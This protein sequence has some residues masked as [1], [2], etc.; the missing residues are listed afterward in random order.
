[1]SL[2]GENS[3]ASKPR[4]LKYYE[5]F[6]KY[7]IHNKIED[8]VEKAYCLLCD[9]TFK[10]GSLKQ[11]NLRRHQVSGFLNICDGQPTKHLDIQKEAKHPESL[12]KGQEFFQQFVPIS[13]RDENLNKVDPLSQKL[14]KVSYDISFLIAKNGKNHTIGE[15]LLKP[16]IMN[17]VE[18]ILGVE[19]AANF[20]A[21][22]VSAGTVK[23]RIVNISSYIELETVRKL[24]E[25]PHF[26]MQLDESTDIVDLAELLVYVRYMV[27][28][29]IEESML[30]VKP[31]PTTTTGAD[32]FNL[33]DSYFQAQ[34]IDWKKCSSIATDGA[35]ALT[36]RH[37]GFIAL[38]KKVCF[39]CNYFFKTNLSSKFSIGEPKCQI[40]TLCSTSRSIGCQSDGS[41]FEKNTGY[42]CT[43]D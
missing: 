17:S 20:Q 21:I 16:V 42:S 35:P 1:M 29:S 19:A 38:V 10:Q 33:V 36:G 13:D 23:R 18:T 31:L 2:S 7:G 43:N 28:D 14:L 40:Y 34:S 3:K 12:G 9:W 11:W 41:R 37:S 15:N 22:A 25:S 8:G 24:R 26:S 6:L 39:F 30:F 5:S 27:N 4:V 32:I